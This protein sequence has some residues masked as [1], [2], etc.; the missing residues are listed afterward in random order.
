M[1]RIVAVPI[2]VLFL[3]L[4]FAHSA[5]ADEVFEFASYKELMAYFEELGYTE[6]TWQYV[7]K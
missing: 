4:P 2:A 7:I 3:L 1:K 5:L 6:A